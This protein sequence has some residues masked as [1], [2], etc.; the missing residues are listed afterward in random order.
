MQTASNPY[1]SPHVTL[2]YEYDISYMQFWRTEVVLAAPSTQR[3]TLIHSFFR[4]I[5]RSG[6]QKSESAVTNFHVS[7]YEGLGPTHQK[8]QC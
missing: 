1:D 4:R 6:H 3:R 7:I 8:Y 5:S 2:A